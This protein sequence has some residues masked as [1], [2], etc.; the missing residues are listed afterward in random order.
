MNYV[1][2]AIPFFILLMAVEFAWG[3]IRGN[4][5]Y[6]LNDTLSSLHMGLLSRVMGLLRLGFSG[7]VFTALIAWFGIQSVSTESP[8]VWI[9]AFVAYD[10]CYYWKHRFGHEWRIMWASHVAHHQSEEYNLST[11]LRQTGTD[12]IGFVFYIP[13]Y[14]AG[15]PVEVVISVGSL[16][17]IYQF[18]VH[19]EHIR[20]LGPMEWIFVTPSN[21]RVHHAKNPSYIDK[22]Y[23]GVFIVWD[24]LFG[25]FKDER[26]DETCYYGITHAL[27]SWNPVWANLHV[28]VETIKLAIKTTSWKDKLTIWFKPP[29]WIP[30]DLSPEKWDWQAQKF[31]PA[32]S[33]FTRIYCFTQY[34]VVT[35]TG[36]AAVLQPN[37]PFSL[38]LL[39]FTLV[40]ASLFV[41]GRMLEAA[42]NALQ[43]E[44]IRLGLVLITALAAPAIWMQLPEWFAPALGAYA[45]ICA[46][47][48]LVANRI[49]SLALQSHSHG[50]EPASNG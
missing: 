18:W 41:H 10:C 9:G 46:V 34:W 50:L 1:T 38:S 40:V 14:L 33:R 43:L 30:E 32:I 49:P 2:Y 11:A 26:E 17:L 48:L 44:W 35:A 47:G 8:W 23:G 45:L 15:L 19:T 3:Q 29:A 16:N 24:R 20:R 4:Q 31:D 12:Y 5:T 39:F 22:N 25:T 28:W 13:L 37:L 36:L 42:G 21:H 7:V 27:H 6:R